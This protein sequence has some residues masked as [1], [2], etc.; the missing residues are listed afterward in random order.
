MPKFLPGRPIP[1]SN[2]AA[3][4]VRAP[5][6]VWTGVWKKSTG[7]FPSRFR[8]FSSIPTLYFEGSSWNADCF[9][10]TYRQEIN[11]WPLANQASVFNGVG[12]VYAPHYRQMMYR[13][14]YPESPQ[15]YQDALV[16]Y[17]TAFA[18]VKRAFETFIALNPEGR[19]ILAGHSQGTGHA[20]RLMMEV[21]LPNKD[22]RQGLL[23][24]YLVGNTVTAKDMG[25]FPLCTDPTQTGL[26]DGLAQLRQGFLPQEIR[27]RIPRG[28]PHH[29]VRFAQ[30]Q[31]PLPAQGGALFQWKGPLAPRGE[32]P[33]RSRNPAH[34]TLARPPWMVLP[35]GRLPPRGL[36]HVLVQH[37][38]KPLPARAKCGTIHRVD[39]RALHRVRIGLIPEVLQLAFERRHRHPDACSRPIQK[40]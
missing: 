34:R 3:A 18:D 4:S 2:G 33:N 8:R 15:E 9:D 14:Y 26:L 11:D 39:L 38:G 17:D 37:S 25:D 29:L 5:R 10:A 36:Q 7:R 12:L 23:V 27:A 6:N 32:C 21:I 28:Q 13:G 40:R 31:P 1:P 19:Y 30:T 22:L 35:M 16:A 24:A 20:K